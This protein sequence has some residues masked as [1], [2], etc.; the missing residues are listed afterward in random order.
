MSMQKK[1]TIISSSVAAILTLIK[2]VVGL[3]SGSVS[4]LASAVDSILDM[5]V[6]LFNYFAVLN[7]EK[8]ANKKFNYGKAKIE[9]LAMVI[10]GTIITIS[11]IFLFYEAI[12]KAILGTQSSYL[13]VSIY[14]M[15]L[16]LI[17]TSSLVFYLNYVAKITNSTLIK[18]DALHY[19]TDILSNI[20]VLFSLVVVKFT[21]FE[22]VDVIVALLI[23]G[24]IIYCAFDFIKNGIL[25]LLDS[26][27]D[28]K[29]VEEIENIIKNCQ[30]VTNFH[31]LKSR[32]AANNIFLEVHIVFNPYITLLEAHKISDLLETKIKNLDVTR[33]WHIVIHFDPYDD[34]TEQ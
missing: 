21:S 12:K 26:S 30:N 15:I 16:S 33:T 20:A 11:G 22:L 9:A 24:Y 1:A 31:N 14:I 34:Q 6:S 8:P 4:L 10:E 18:A 27:I 29:L 25:I 13:D 3:V 17:I 19:K 2:L 32:E 5:F 28:N 23:S 7:S